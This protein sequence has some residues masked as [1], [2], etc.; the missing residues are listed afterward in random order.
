[1]KLDAEFV[2]SAFTSGGCPNWNRVE[3]AIAGRS[4]V[5]KSSILNALCARKDLARTSKT[6]GRTRCLNFFAVGER[7]A[8]VDLPGYGYAKMPRAEAHAIAKLMN[9]FLVHR[10]KLVALV[11]LIDSRRG[12]EREEVELARMIEQRNI[13]LVVVATKADKLRNSERRTALGRFQTMLGVQP[14]M[15][16]AENGDGIDELRRRILGCVKGA[17]KRPSNTTLRAVAP[18]YEP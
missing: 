14:I 8:L 17:S 10:E 13:E 18:L 16:S 1:M 7:F 11:L 15:C 3:V 12:P 4:N 5:G 9:D 6:P 2:S